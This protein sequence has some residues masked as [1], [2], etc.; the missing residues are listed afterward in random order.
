MSLVLDKVSDPVSLSR[1]I[2]G[3]YLELKI[4]KAQGSRSALLT[5]ADARKL[6]YALLLDAE[7]LETDA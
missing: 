5:P 1:A 3:K 4:G 2:V 6:A 7:N